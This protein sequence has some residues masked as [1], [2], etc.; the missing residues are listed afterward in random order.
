MTQKRIY[1]LE[2]YEQADPGDPGYIAPT[3]LRMAIDST[4]FPGE[5]MYV[6]YLGLLSDKHFEVGRVTGLADR[7]VSVT[8]GTAFTGVPV[9]IENLRV[10]R[11]TEVVTGKYKIHDVQHYH[12]TNTPVTS[13]G[14]SF[15]IE[16]SE[17][18]TGVIYEYLFTE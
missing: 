18:L 10:Y 7:E 1:A 14:F 11:I 5:A 2:L 16:D 8:F 12:P 9:G 17:S 15:T 6:P 3:S 4:Q 13:S